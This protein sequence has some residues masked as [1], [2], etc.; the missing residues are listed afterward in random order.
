MSRPSAALP[1]AKSHN[2]NTGA[3]AMTIVLLWVLIIGLT[4]LFIAAAWIAWAS[5]LVAVALDE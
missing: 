2:A 4:L 1:A 5:E 3:P